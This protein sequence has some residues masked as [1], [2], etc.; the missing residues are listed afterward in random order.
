MEIKLTEFTHGG[1]CGCKIA[2]DVLNRLL[3]DLKNTK[4]VPNLLIGLDNSDDASV[5]QINESQAVVVTTDFFAPVV[6]DPYD[7]GRIAATNAFSDVYAMGGKPILALSVLGFPI[8]KI[9]E[10]VI[11]KILQGGE[12]VCREIKV[13][14]AGGHSIDSKEPFY[15]LIALGLINPKNIKANSHARAGDRLIITKPIGVGVISAALKAQTVNQKTYQKF[16]HITTQ[17]NSVGS[18]LAEIEGIHAMTDVTGFGL[19]GHLLE[20]CRASRLVARITLDDVPIIPEALELIKSGVMTGASSRNWRSFKDSVQLTENDKWNTI[21]CDPQTSG[22]LLITTDE[23]YSLEIIQILRQAGCKD[24][25]E[26][27]Y[28]RSGKPFVIGL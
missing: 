26:I 21:L 6:D 4:L 9:P 3:K 17:L 16:L 8:D 27:G 24:A 20:V 5:Y 12:S 23:K 10:H 7:F 13:P 22:G 28:L 11:K 19:I 1:G 2:P 18:R 14:I 15:G 25:K